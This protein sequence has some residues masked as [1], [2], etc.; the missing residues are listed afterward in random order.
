MTAADVMMEIHRVARRND[1]CRNGENQR[2][3]SHVRLVGQ[4]TDPGGELC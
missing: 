3:Y 1:I 2:G 4:S